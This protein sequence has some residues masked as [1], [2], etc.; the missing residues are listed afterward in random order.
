MAK[1][2]DVIEGLEILAKY[3]AQGRESHDIAAEHDI[4]Y[5]PQDPG[6]MTDEDK[7]RLKALNWFVDG[8]T[9]SWAHF[10]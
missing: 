5:G 1:I 8:E 6:T 2:G 7:E 3:A 10:V 4:L 9:D